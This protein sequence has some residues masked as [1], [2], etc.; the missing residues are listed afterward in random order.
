MGFKSAFDSRK[1]EITSVSYKN[2]AS[3]D[4]IFLK[5]IIKN[6]ES[7]NPLNNRNFDKY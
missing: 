7:R 2:K 6:Q 1:R 5:N 3:A 4:L